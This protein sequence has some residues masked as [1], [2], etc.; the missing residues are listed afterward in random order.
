MQ[1]YNLLMEE[2]LKKIKE[3]LKK[4]SLLLH[5]CC[6]PCLT[7]V[8]HLLKDYFDITVYYYNPCIYPKEEYIK[9]LNEVK[10]LCS[11]YSVQLFEGE[12]NPSDFYNATLG[13]EKDKEGGERCK[14]CLAMRIDS[15]GKIAKEK[16]FDYFTTTLSIS[17]LKNAEHLNTVGVLTQNKYGVRY[18]VSDF[19]KKDGY[20]NS[21]RLS[22]EYSLYR[23]NYCGCE[24]SLSER[25]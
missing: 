12:Y 1:N 21:I 10:K 18:L 5:A 16:A 22:K 11:I 7:Q 2:N 25:S 14:I 9:R 17:P 3:S 15:A 6:A 4:P 19:K 20:L 8:L 23:Q 24:F 13:R